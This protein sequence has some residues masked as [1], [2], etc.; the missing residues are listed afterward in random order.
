MNSRKIKPEHAVSFLFLIV[1]LLISNYASANIFNVSNTT[2]FRKALE[3]VA[4]NGQDDTIILDAGT[5]K[6]IDDGLGAFKFVDKEKHKLTI[7]AK[8]GL[9]RDDVILDGDNT[10]QVLNYKSTK[11]A[12]LT[13][14]N[15]TIRNGKASIGGGIYSNG[16][17]A[18]TNSTI[19]GNTASGTHDFY[20]GGIYSKGGV[21]VTNSTISGNT[22]SG[23]YYVY[24][25]GIYSKGGVTVTNSIISGNTASG[26]YAVWGGGVYSKGNITLT[27]STIFGNNAINGSGGGIYC[28]TSRRVTVTSS[29]ITGNTAHDGGGIYCYAIRVI[30][31]NSTITGNT[32]EGDGGG[33]YCESYILNGSYNYG[34]VTVTNSTISGNNAT[35]GGGAGVYCYAS[36]VTLANS[37]ISGNTANIYGGGVYGVG[38]FINNI[39]TDNSSDISF[40]GNSS[41][42]YNNYIDYTKLEDDSYGLIIKKNNIQP[43]EGSLNFAD[44]DFRLGDGSIAINKGLNPESTQFKKLIKDKSVLQT[45][46][47]ALKKDMDGNKRIRGTTIDLGPYEYIP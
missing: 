23:G 39:F 29:I 1:L 3:N 28:Y 4:L 42:V 11:K 12:T 17:V 38:T 41:N 14:I 9:T 31:K 27:N 47:K 7:K 21:T 22:A 45:V 2:Q 36:I 19:S 8:K 44:S 6:T 33:I 10:H 46:L 30:I 43:N 37:T 13:I 5:Y 18:V 40:T 35:N 26:S 24:G 34:R 16:G 25:G 20:G 32:A 15:I